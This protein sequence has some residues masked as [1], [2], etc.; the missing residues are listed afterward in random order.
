MQL[1]Y[2][3]VCISFLQHGEVE[4]CRAFINLGH[5][6]WQLYEVCKSTDML[7]RKD[8]TKQIVFIVYLKTLL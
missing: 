7:T 6:D 3:F 8:A 2:C 5:S 1:F 4:I